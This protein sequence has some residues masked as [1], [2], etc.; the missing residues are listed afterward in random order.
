MRRRA[1]SK[2]R[3]FGE[4]QLA[5]G[6]AKLAPRDAHV[7]ADG[8]P[9]MTAINEEIVPL[10]FARHGFAYGIDHWRVT[11][12]GAERGPKIGRI[13]LTK[14]HI[15]RAGAGQAHAIARL[16]EIVGHG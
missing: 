10:R 9:T 1:A 5:F 14:A 16:T 15:K 3:A 7:T 6:D 4:A 12:T 11:L 8:R 2:A 13:L